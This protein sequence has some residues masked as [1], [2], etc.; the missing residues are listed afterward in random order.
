[1]TIYKNVV[2][3]LNGRTLATGNYSL[4][5]GGGDLT[6][7][8]GSENAS[9]KITGAGILINSTVTGSNTVTLES[10]TLERTARIVICIFSTGCGGRNRAVSTGQRTASAI[11]CPETGRESI[12]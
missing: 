12:R 8:D 1:M 3:D 5:I 2:L 6:I 10:G 9:G 4:Q 11:R 7:Q